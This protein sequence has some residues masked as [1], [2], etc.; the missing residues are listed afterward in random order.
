MSKIYCNCTHDGK[1]NTQGV[2]FQEQQYG[3]GIRIGN[4]LPKVQG[5]TQEYQ[6][7]ICGTKTDKG[8]L[9]CKRH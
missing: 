3:K 9:S 1:G 2:E 7:T 4:E 6:C 5:R 8:L